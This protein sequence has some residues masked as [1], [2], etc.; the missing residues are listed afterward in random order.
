VNV[1]NVDEGS[2][3]ETQALASGSQVVPA[4]Q[5]DAAPPSGQGEGEDA[6]SGAEDDAQLGQAL[7][8]DL[9]D[10]VFAIVEDLTVLVADVRV[11]HGDRRS[12]AVGDDGE[13]L[14][15]RDVRGDALVDRPEG[16]RAGH[17]DVEVQGGRPG[18]RAVAGEHQHHA[19]LRVDL[20]AA[21]GSEGDAAH[22]EEREDQDEEGKPALRRRP[23]VGRVAEP[24]VPAGAG[25]TLSPGRKR[26]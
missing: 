14:G 23:W 12:V 9:E 8:G 20:S 1:G 11:H 2:S 7:G 6:T 10:L 26:K 16:G 17:G 21:A 25:P 3:P 22:G 5:V 18:K 13:G 15:Q 4:A 19:A 24:R